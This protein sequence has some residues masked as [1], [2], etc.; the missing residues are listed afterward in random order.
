VLEE[1]YDEIHA[2]P[3]AGPGQDYGHASHV[4]STCSMSASG[5]ALVTEIAISRSS[6]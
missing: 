3:P 2:G 5:P 4:G 6:G 1:L